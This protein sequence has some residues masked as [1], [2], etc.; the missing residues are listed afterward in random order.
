MADTLQDKATSLHASAR[1]HKQASAYHRREAKRKMIQ[2]AALQ[3]KA[4]LLG[5]KIII[6]PNG[7][8]NNHGQ[9]KSS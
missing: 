4:G 6:T 7:E 8:G 9:A 1:E 2:L 3:N 5:I